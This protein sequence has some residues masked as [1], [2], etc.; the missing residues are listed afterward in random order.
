MKMMMYR[1]MSGRGL[2]F[3]E[4]EAVGGEAGAEGADA[5]A[6]A[7]DA[8][9]EEDAE[10][11]SAEVG[12]DAPQ[13]GSPAEVDAE[14]L[15]REYSLADDE[16]GELEETVEDPPAGQKD[17]EAYAVEFPE[18]FVPTEE[19]SR[20]VTPV[21]RELGIDGKLFGEAAARVVEAL[22]REEVERMAE[23]DRALKEE[24]GADYKANK[25]EARRFYKWCQEEGGLSAEDLRVFESPKGVKLLYRMSRRL[26]ERGAVEGRGAVQSEAAWAD[27]VSRDPSHPDYKA[28]RDVDNPRFEEVVAR[29]NRARG[30]RF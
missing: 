19:F 25:R 18:H 27:A 30:I 2:F 9:S 15:R 11:G 28:L 1:W 10:T 23:S 29:Y 24:W 14:G 12:D 13:E 20:L 26:G 5:A 17:A 3:P 6:P 8:A 4:P 16:E 22:Q 21:G 7:G